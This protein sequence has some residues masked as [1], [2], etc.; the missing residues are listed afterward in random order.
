M[1]P[2][3]KREALADTC[4]AEF[5]SRLSRLMARFT[6]NIFG[7]MKRKYSILKTLRAH[8]NRIRRIIIANAILHNISIRWRQEDIMID[9]E[10][11]AVPPFL[12]VAIIKDA[13]DV[14]PEGGQIMRDQLLRGMDNRRRR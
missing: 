9:D 2:Y 10:P 6:E 8:Y 3:T 1:K 13:A 12:R 11:A 14:V 4:K 7:I 5:N